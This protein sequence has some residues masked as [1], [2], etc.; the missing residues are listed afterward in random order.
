M[1]CCASSST[2]CSYAGVERPDIIKMFNG[3]AQFFQIRDDYCNICDPKYWESKGFFEDLD[4]GKMSYSVIH[5][6]EH[7]T[8]EAQQ[9]LQ[10]LL[11]LRGKATLADKCE[12]YSL[13]EKSGSLN[14]T[15]Q[16]LVQ[17]SNNLKAQCASFPALMHVIQQ[18]PIVE[19][20][21]VA[22]IFSRFGSG[23]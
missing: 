4:E 23:T 6:F 20:P 1:R 5:Y 19:P 8:A 12:A 2:V 22:N 16:H 13:L 10:R 15:Y 9:S 3:L 11:T 18:L 21:S 17:A 7:G 14:Y